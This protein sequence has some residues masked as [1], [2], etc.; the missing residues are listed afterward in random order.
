MRRFKF[1][2]ATKYGRR[3]K[4]GVMNGYESKYADVLEARRLAGEIVAWHFEAV[5]LKLASDCRYTPDFMVQLADGSIEF[6]DVKGGI[7]DDKA[8][9]KI[10]CAAE[11]FFQFCFVMEQLQSKKNG[12]GWKRTEY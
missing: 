7:I 9:V 10:K 8:V 1:A 2:G 12:G 11:K 4:P 5:T 6:V 3:H